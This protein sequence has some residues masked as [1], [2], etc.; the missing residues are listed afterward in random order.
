MSMRERSGKREQK[1]ISIYKWKENN[2][3]EIPII[4]EIQI[5]NESY[6][7]KQKAK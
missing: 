4:M 2:K 5:F 7:K 6:T 1:T 3:R